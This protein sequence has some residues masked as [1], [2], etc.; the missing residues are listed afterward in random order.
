MTP[1]P[2]SQMR[3][4]AKYKKENITKVSVEFNKNNTEDMTM[5]EF[6]NKQA[7]KQGFIKQ[8]IRESMKHSK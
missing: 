8:L 1:R 4:V 2:P 7:T 3:Y 6:L 5:L